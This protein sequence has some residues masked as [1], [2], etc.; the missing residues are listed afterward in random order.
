MTQTKPIHSTSH[1]DLYYRD[2]VAWSDE[3]ALLLE[4]ER[5]T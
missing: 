2:F 4:Q 3:Q 5:F 1:S